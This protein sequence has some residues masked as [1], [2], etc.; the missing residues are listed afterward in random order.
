MAEISDISN[1]ILIELQNIDSE[2]MQA[3]GKINDFSL[4]IMQEYRDKAM[5]DQVQIGKLITEHGIALVDQE[6]KR[7]EAVAESAKAEEER[8]AALETAV[9][10][11]ADLIEVQKQRE[12][13]TLSQSE[14]IINASNNESDTIIKNA[15]DTTQSVLDNINAA[16]NEGSDNWFADQIGMNDEQVDQ[17]KQVGAATMDAFKSISGSILEIRRKEAEEKKAIIEKEL[18]ATLGALEK[19]RQERLIAAGFVVENNAQSLEAQLEDARNSGDEAL[20]YELERKLQEKAI[21]DEFD[22]LAEEANKEAAKKKAKLE[23]DVAKQEHA[24]K[25]VDAINA[26]AMAVVQA[27]ASAGNPILGAIFA[28][29]TTA[30]TGFQIA[31]IA[32]NPPKMPTFSTGGIVPGTSITG[33]Q[34]LASLNSREGVLTMDDQKYLFDQIQNKKLGGAVKATIVIYY[35]FPINFIYGDERIYYDL[36]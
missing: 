4:R 25:L 21:N 27:F 11:E 5:E 3:L 31:A 33:D 10:L 15:E 23:Y 14:N 9:E 35:Y 19:E 20:A 7:R 30:A 34:V 24:M 17:L 8:N 32:S 28:A 13:E 1:E 22:L 16:P 29:L 6:I 36:R 18:E 2:I 12:S 26:A